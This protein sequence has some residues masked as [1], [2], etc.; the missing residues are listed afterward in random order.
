MRVLIVAPMI[1]LGWS[2][3]AQ[4][5][6]APK[7]GPAYTSDGQL[8]LPADYREWVYLTSGFDMS[9][10]PVTTMDH[11]MFDNVFVNP[12][13]WRTFKAS[14]TWPDKT[15]LVL[16]LRHAQ[17]KGSINRNG[18]FQDSD[19]MGVEVHVKDQTRF[20]GNWAFFRFPPASATAKMIPTSED[21]YSCH[22]DHGAVD[23]TFAQFYPTALPIATD[24]KTLSPAYLRDGSK[25]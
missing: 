24:K 19:V 5:D 1:V 23:T 9:Y 21:C 11:H 3:L 12:E 18:N 15:V 10:T 7:S 13:A 17:S 14:G 4:T 6:K 16:E 20:P 25:P 8:R 2:V 22:R